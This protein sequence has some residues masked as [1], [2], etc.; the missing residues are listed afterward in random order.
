MHLQRTAMV[1]HKNQTLIFDTVR[2]TYTYN[3]HEE[4]LCSYA[5]FDTIKNLKGPPSAPTTAITKPITFINNKIT[6]TPNGILQPGTIYLADSKKHCQYALTI[7]VSQISFLR[8][9]RYDT[10]WHYL[11]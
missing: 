7:P 8:R 6:F 2:N 9:Y 4:R 1:T 11:K 10:S 3:G 5:R